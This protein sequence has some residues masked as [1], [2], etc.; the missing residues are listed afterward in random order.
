MDETLEALLALAPLDALPRTGW[1]QR[2]VAAPES[3]AGHLAG[4]A[5]LALALAPRVEPALDVDRCL[6]LAVVHDAPEALTGDLPR[7]ARERLPEGAKAAAEEAAAR[8]VLAP[9]SPVALAR[10]HEVEAGETREARLVR[11]C[12]RLALGVRLV[13]YLRAGQRGLDEFAHG[14]EA[15]D[16]R[17]FPPAAEMRDTLLDAI[18]RQG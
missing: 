18:T 12:D 3:V 13:A 10:F 7:G 6:A 9:L 2:G 11:L 14:I 15:L 16:C 17:E 4:T 1:I 8:A 5:L